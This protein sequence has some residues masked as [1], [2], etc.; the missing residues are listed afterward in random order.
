MVFQLSKIVCLICLIVFSLYFFSFAHECTENKAYIVNAVGTATLWFRL[1][2]GN[3]K[4]GFIDYSYED[5]LI[6]RLHNIIILCQ[7]Y[8]LR[9]EFNDLARLKTNLFKKIWS[10]VES[11]KKIS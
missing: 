9:Y 2:E 8:C 10:V 7:I 4:L 3:T 11:Q 6:I 1:A 5:S